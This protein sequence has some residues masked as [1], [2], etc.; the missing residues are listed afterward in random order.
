MMPVVTPGL[1][2][3]QVR[4][5]AAR[6]G[7]RE[8][9][10]KNKV[11]LEVKKEEFIPYKIKLAMKEVPTGSRRKDDSGKAIA[12]DDVFNIKHC[13]PRVFSFEEAV[14]AHRES[15]H[16]TVYNKPDSVLMAFIELDMR[17]EKKTRFLDPFSRIVLLPYQFS[18]GPDKTILA[19]AK[20]QDQQRE[21]LEAGALEAGGPELVK[22]ILTGNY[23]VSSVDFVVAHS[24]ILADMIPVRGLMKK[25]FPSQKAGTLGVDMKGMVLK[26]LKG[27]EYQCSRDKHELDYG[28]VEMPV[29]RLDMDKAELEANLSFLLRDLDACKPRKADPFITRLM[30]KCPPSCE[31]FLLDHTRYVQS[32]AGTKSQRSKVIEEAEEED[33]V[34]DNVRERASN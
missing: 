8:R 27:F 4:C 11:K 23:D 19:F 34:N 7:T 32:Q 25:K 2:T 6:K 12:I 30:L 24:N 20:G 22:K 28:C 29:G 18:Y 33:D 9:K 26:Y 1:Q 14:E 5:F 21:A 10:S 31:I 13:Q 15:M 16:P 3:V 17:M